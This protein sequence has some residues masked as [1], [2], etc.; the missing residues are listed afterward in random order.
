MTTQTMV[1]DHVAWLSERA[2][3]LDPNRPVGIEVLSEMPGT[4]TIIGRGPSKRQAV[5][6]VYKE[7]ERRGLP[8]S[9]LPSREGSR[10]RDT[11]DIWCAA[12]WVTK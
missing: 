7:A 9:E 2:D 8:T 11:L 12:T 3:V 4:L 5:E 1:F 6:E 10:L